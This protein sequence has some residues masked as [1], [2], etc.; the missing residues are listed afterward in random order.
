[1][2]KPKPATKEAPVLSALDLE[3]QVSVPEAADFKGISTDTF[4]RHYG[5]I[6]NRPSTRR[7]T[8][9]IRDLLEARAAE[10]TA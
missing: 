3:R 2:K 6:I 5:H 9:K 10:R 7:C 4:K 8:V 1:M